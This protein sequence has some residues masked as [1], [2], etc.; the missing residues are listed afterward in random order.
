MT[1]CG[2]VAVNMNPLRRL[3][4]DEALRLVRGDMLD[5]SETVISNT[6]EALA[7]LSR[8][9]FPT[10]HEISLEI[11]TILGRSTHLIDDRQVAL[12]RQTD[13]HRLTALAAKLHGL[14]VIPPLT[15]TPSAAVEGASAV[16]APRRAKKE[17]SR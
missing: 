12:L 14:D 3:T 6:A 1:E 17:K 10:L 2:E 8:R 15:V 13:L 4:F 5:E 9:K 16:P 7:A 11:M